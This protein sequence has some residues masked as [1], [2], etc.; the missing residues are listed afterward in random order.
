MIKSNILASGSVDI[1]TSFRYGDSI[2]CATESKQ[3]FV[4]SHPYCY[5]C[6]FTTLSEQPLSM[7]KDLL[8]VQTG[9][10]TIGKRR[11]QNDKRFTIVYSISQ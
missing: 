2:H 4:D 10:H 9:N 6:L 1:L 11:T 8:G 7:G 5:L 3:V